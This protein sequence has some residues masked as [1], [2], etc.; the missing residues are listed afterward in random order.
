MAGFF[1]TIGSTLSAVDTV[2]SSTARRI[3]VWAVEEET[4]TEL[5]HISRMMEIRVDC[6]VE[7]ANQI[8]KRNAAH[9]NQDVV[10]ASKMIDQYYAA[11]NKQEQ[12]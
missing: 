10:A 3:G 5:R 11:K 1:R 4:K 8:N 2:A 6:E 9:Q 7:L 12:Q